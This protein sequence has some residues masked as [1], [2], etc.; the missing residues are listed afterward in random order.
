V[1]RQS[2]AV[3]DFCKML[4]EQWA[5]IP[6][7]CQGLIKRDLEDYFHFDNNDRRN[8]SHIWTLGADCDRAEWEQVRKLW[9]GNANANQN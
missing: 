8:G 7:S 6:E 1:G 5:T 4:I 2:Y 3:S 9:E